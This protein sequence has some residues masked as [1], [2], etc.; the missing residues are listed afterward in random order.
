MMIEI[1]EDELHGICGDLASELLGDMPL[2]ASVVRY[3]EKD[4]EV[5]DFAAIVAAW[6]QYSPKYVKKDMADRRR[7]GMPCSRG[8][9]ENT[10]EFH[11]EAANLLER[12]SA[13]LPAGSPA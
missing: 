13:Q 7:S 8:I 11:D 2:T 3:M 1:S 6:R 5:E 12:L 4:L 10:R 9:S